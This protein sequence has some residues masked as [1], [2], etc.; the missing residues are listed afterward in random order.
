MFYGKYFTHRLPGSI[1]YNFTQFTLEMCAAAESGKKIPNCPILEVQNNSRSSMVNDD[2][3]TK[4]LSP[5][6]V[7]ISSMSMTISNCFHARRANSGKIRTF[8]RYPSFTPSFEGNPLPLSQV[9]KISSQKTRV[10]GTAH[11]K[12][13]VILYPVYTIKLAGRAGYILAG[14]ASSK[15]T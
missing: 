8:R 2:D 14:R 3:T 1:A 15:F 6:L 11:N 9:L 12:H 13:F 10:L 7:T 5:V 4:S